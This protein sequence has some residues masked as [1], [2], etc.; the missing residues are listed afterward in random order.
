MEATTA[1]SK[2]EDTIRA[3]AD[4][5][6]SE[7]CLAKKERRMH[8]NQKVFVSQET[9]RD[10]IAGMSRLIENAMTALFTH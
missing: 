3:L 6:A 8:A 10:T 7:K 5:L 9:F 4:H 2:P 1:P